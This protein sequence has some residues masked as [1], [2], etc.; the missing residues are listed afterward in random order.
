MLLGKHLSSYFLILNIALHI[1]YFIIIPEVAIYKLQK[2][3]DK[4]IFS[5]KFPII[6][7]ILTK[8]NSI[9]LEQ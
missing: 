1:R 8:N 4:R 6:F 5:I 3:F 7:I 2:A 9:F